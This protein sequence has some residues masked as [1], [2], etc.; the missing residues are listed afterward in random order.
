MAI[1]NCQICKVEIESIGKPKFCKK[2]GK[3]R[4][5]EK[6]RAFSKAHDRQYASLY[7]GSGV[8]ANVRHKDK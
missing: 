4:T 6:S 5:K 2:C 3:E 1:F 7:K 8:I